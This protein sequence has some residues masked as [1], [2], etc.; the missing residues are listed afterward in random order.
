MGNALATISKDKYK[1]GDYLARPD[2]IVVQII[3]QIPGDL[4]LYA[5]RQ[6]HTGDDEDIIWFTEYEIDNNGLKPYTPDFKLWQTVA[7]GDVIKVDEKTHKKVLARIGGLILLSNSPV[8][9]KTMEGAANLAAQLDE[10]L[11]TDGK[12]TSMYESGKE[13]MKPFISTQG[14]FKV[15]EDHWH[16]VDTLALKNWELMRE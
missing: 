8:D 5:L 10:L 7:V 14:A 6:H 15:A 12:M 13:K 9:H 3:G 1:V 2:S 4:T 11:D 16:A